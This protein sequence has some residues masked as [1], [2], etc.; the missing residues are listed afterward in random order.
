MPY[1]NRT[2]RYITRPEMESLNLPLRQGDVREDGFS[3]KQYYIRV[4]N[5]TGEESK[6]YE[7][8]YSQETL[9]KQKILKAR[10]KKKNSDANK[11]FIRR[12]KS[13]FGCSVCGYKKSLLALHFHHV[14]PKV[15]EVSKMF[16]YSRKNIKKEI[17]NCI[18]VCSNCHCEIHDKKQK[19][20]KD[21]Y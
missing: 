20:I 14:G 7:Q 12:F 18:L 6:I 1:R 15:N 9:R 11:K 19:D 8:W 4:N 2:V 3:F 21:A 13:I 16:G 10:Q 5:D 17:R